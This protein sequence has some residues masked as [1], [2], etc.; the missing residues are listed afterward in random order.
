MHSL[1]HEGGLEK[2]RKAQDNGGPVTASAGPVPAI[3]GG[4]QAEVKASADPREGTF[5]EMPLS[6]L[7]L[8]PLQPV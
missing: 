7:N 4:R 8:K 5:T 2:N 3:S 1:E 6:L